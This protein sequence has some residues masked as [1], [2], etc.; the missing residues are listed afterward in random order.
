MRETE[1]NMLLENGFRPI[2][3]AAELAPRSSDVSGTA[4]IDLAHLGR[5]TLGDPELE[6]EVLDLFADQMPVTIDALKKA[7]SD[8]DW[9]MAAHTLKG[10]SRAVGAWRLAELALQAERIGGIYDREDAA[11]IVQQIEAAAAEAAVYIRG[12]AHSQAG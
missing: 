8:K 2:T 9:Q 10:S 7:S 4:P 11:E 12:L 6:R 3:R 5:Y 1:P